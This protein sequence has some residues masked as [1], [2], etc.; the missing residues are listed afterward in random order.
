MLICPIID[1]HICG[2]TA[3]QLHKTLGLFNIPWKGQDENSK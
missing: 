2:E 3:M 1:E